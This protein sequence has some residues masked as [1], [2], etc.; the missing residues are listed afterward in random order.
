MSDRRVITS[1]KAPS[2]VGPY[3]QAIASGEFIFTAGQIP[4]NPET[5]RIIEGDFKEQVRQVLHNISEILHEAHSDLEHV[6]KLT[7]FLTEMYRFQDL[8]N[9]FKEFF[10]FDPPARSVVEVSKLPLS[11][12]VEIECIAVRKK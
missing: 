10:S 12:E 5:G 3:N 6:V 2:A 1:Y 8:N 4:L 9:V 7:V 11:A